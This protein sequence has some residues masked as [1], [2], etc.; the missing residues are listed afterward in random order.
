MDG[1]HAFDTCVLWPYVNISLCRK[2]RP[3]VV[4]TVP[5]CARSA[6]TIE[7]IPTLPWAFIPSPSHLLGIFALCNLQIQARS[8]TYNDETRIK[9]VAMSV[10]PVNPVTESKYLIDQIKKYAARETGM[11]H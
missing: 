8:D 6:A 10:T 4:F 5:R 1:T 3:V 7:S 11:V 9:C 2:P